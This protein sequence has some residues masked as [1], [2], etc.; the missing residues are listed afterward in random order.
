M[1]ESILVVCDD[2]KSVTVDDKEAVTNV[3]FEFRRKRN[4]VNFKCYEK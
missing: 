3:Y 4:G 2:V 1:L